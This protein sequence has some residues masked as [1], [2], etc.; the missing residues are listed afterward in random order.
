MSEEVD[1]KGYTIKGENGVFM[2]F[3]FGVPV[4]DAYS[5]ENAKRII[6]AGKI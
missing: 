5:I 6:D 4:A 1:Y 2:I 3:D